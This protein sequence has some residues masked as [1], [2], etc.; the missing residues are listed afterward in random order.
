M[1]FAARV[2]TITHVV[3]GH[4]LERAKQQLQKVSFKAEGRGATNL[5][6][7]PQIH[8]LAL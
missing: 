8:S 6:G 3:A 1:S 2:C 5:P 4:W 7:D